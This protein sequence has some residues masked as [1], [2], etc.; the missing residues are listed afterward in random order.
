MT[1]QSKAD[2][3]LVRE[4]REFLEEREA[5]ES[6]LRQTMLDDLR[7]VFVPG[8]Q[9]DRLATQKR[10]GRPMYSFNRTAGAVNQLVGDM[11]MSQPGTKVRALNNRGAAGASQIIGGLLR[12]IHAQSRSDRVFAESFKYTVAGGWGYWRVVSEYEDDVPEGELDAASFHQSLRIRRV[13]NPLTVYLDEYADP[14]GRGA[15]RGMVSEK[16]SVSKYKALFGD[17]AY[18]NLPGVRDTKGWHDDKKVRIGEFYRMDC[19]QE[20]LALLSDGRAERWS[21][22]LEEDL[23]SLKATGRDISVV[24]RR[25][26]KRWYCTWVK[27]DGAN[28][29]EGPFEYTYRHIPI[30]RAP[31]RFV[32]IEGEDLY[33][34]LIAHSK[35]AARVYNYNR[36]AMVETTALA[37]R[38]PYIGTAK[39]FKGY[40]EEWAGSSTSNAPFLRFDADPDFPGERPER[41]AGAQVPEAFIALAAHDAEDI[42]QTTGY[43]N[44]A[45]DQQTAAGDAESG[46]ALR[47]RLRTAD[48]GSYE[49][50]DNFTKALE[51]T[52]EVL[53]DMLPVH[54]V[55]ERV[56]RLLGVDGRESFESLDPQILRKGK[57]DV[58]VTLG[59]AYATARME[60]AEGLLEA[61][62]RLPII[63]EVAPD[64][65][66]RNF[67]VQGTDELEQRI[68]LRLVQ[69]GTIA[70]NEQDL[71][72]L[73]EFPQPEAD[74]VQQQLARRLAAQASK[75]EASAAKTAAEAETA[76]RREMLEMRE[77]LATIAKTQAETMLVL[78]ELRQPAAPKGP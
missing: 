48:S 66:V 15:M 68:R 61:A 47:T 18:S 2:S 56:V 16:I 21:R 38:A 70:P 30:I 5:A 26:V 22:A 20:Q 57:F 77:T 36:S 33:Q 50:V 45:L 55:R 7:F 72:A 24:E 74:P 35:D 10:K 58:T 59:P 14:W 60:A 41:Q 67:D 73:K 32:N 49:F 11:R 76:L 39:M 42:R 12:D 9:W 53:I 19:R 69:A 8:A 6:D 62:E 25:K 40:E 13:K 43:F 64:L 34:S 27:M 65:I 37:P 44:P 54:Y 46:R 75:D 63:S 51:Y 23:E 52:D 31:G 29:L 3:D 1:R 17:E 78:K 28:V 4:G 71:Q